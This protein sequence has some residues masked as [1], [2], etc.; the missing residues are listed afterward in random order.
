MLTGD[1][2][3]ILTHVEPILPVTD[4]IETVNYWSNVLGFSNKWTWGDPVDY[5]GVN[6]Q[7]VFIQFLLAPKLAERSKGNSIFIRVKNLAASYRFH[8]NKN[9]EII[10]PLENKPWG[11]AG[12]TLRDN[13]GYHIIFAGAPIAEQ[14]TEPVIPETVNIIARTPT[15]KEYLKL[16][17]SVGWA[18]F[19]N[20]DL[21]EKILAAPIFA[22]VAEDPATNHVIGCAL[23]LGDGAGF[24]YVKDLMVHPG[25]QKKGVGSMLMKA[26]TSWMDRNAPGVGHAYLFTGENLASF[27]KQFDFRQAFG[28]VREINNKEETAKNF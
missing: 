5:G 18:R 25:W 22:V 27:Y 3:P 14:K 13:N 10:E 15:V 16:V 9:A 24:Y 12:Y 23:V 17:E 7:G 28:M 2:T 21:V 11:M 26:L 8:Q 20:P 19:T 4:I 6:W 1:N